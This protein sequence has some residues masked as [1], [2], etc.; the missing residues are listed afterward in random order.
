MRNVLRENFVALQDPL[1]ALNSRIGSASPLNGEHDVD[2][3]LTSVMSSIASDL[4][5]DVSDVEESED[6][7]DRCRPC[8]ADSSL[9]R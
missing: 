7:L 1:S 6:R 8:T 4:E 2:D 3:T 5:I 9:M